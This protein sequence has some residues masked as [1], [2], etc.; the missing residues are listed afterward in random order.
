MRA[1]MLLAVFAERAP[2]HRVPQNGQRAFRALLDAR[3]QIPG[4]AVLNLQGY[5][6]DVTPDERPGLPDRLRDRQPETLTRGL[7]D[8]HVG[9]RL[10]GV[11]LDCADVV[12]VVE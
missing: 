1:H 12:E 8:E 4:Y 6:A 3:N 10:E 11:D 5:A 9:V 2:E 7:L